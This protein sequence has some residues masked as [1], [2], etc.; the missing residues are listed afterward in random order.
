MANYPRPNRMTCSHA[1]LLGEFH[2]SSFTLEASNC[3]DV[4]SFS[5]RIAHMDNCSKK[6]VL[7]GRY[8]QQ[9]AQCYQHTM[10]W[11]SVECVLVQLVS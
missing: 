9:A 6:H 7:V 2:P 4:D 1:R 11:Q 3:G 8:V 5:L 10:R